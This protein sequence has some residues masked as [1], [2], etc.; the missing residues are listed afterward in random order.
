M[1]YY[2]A[3]KKI[4]PYTAT[5]MEIIILSEVNQTE[6]NIMISLTWESKKNDTNELIHKTDS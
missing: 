1:E 3:I 6:T 4:M 5:W 2:L